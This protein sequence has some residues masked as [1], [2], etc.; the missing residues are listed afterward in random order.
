MGITETNKISSEFAKNIQSL[1]HGMLKISSH[2]NRDHIINI[3]FDIQ[4]TNLIEFIKFIKFNL[5]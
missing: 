5:M 1:L 2:P 3:I 4:D